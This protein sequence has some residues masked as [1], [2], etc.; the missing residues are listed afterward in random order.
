MSATKNLF[1]TFKTHDI[2]ALVKAA[3]AEL[4]DKP[5]ESLHKQ[6]YEGIDITPFY[7]PQ[8]RSPLPLRTNGA[9]QIA[10][11]ASW[12][13][14]TALLTHGADSVWIGVADWQEAHSL[15]LAQ[16]PQ[17]YHLFF[18]NRAALEAALPHTQAAK[19]LS[20]DP[21]A[22]ALRSGK[23]PSQADWQ[24][25][26]ALYQQNNAV[27]SVDI[28]PVHNAGGSATQELGI[29]LAM[30]V[31]NLHQLS[32]AQ[33][34]QPATLKV[35]VRWQVAIGSQYF[36]EI[37]KLRALRL[38][39]RLVADA[40]G[41]N[42]QL[43]IQAHTATWNKSLL[44]SYNNML[45]NTTEAMAAVIGGADVLSV[46]PHNHI[47]EGQSAFA[48]RI[49]LNTALLLREEAHLDK[50]ADAAAGAYFVEQLSDQL[51]DKAW[52]Y[53]QS[54]EAAGG[55]LKA[56]AKNIPQNDIAEVAT[57]KRQDFAAGKLVMV[58]VNKFPNA[59][60]TLKEV[61]GAPAP[62]ADWQAL[63]EQRLAQTPLT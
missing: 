38:L 37:A 16:A 18:D 27:L 46:W 53:F 32:E 22:L 55:F 8:G 59:K 60:D 19:S 45:R 4:K 10:A 56:A 6:S 41:L 29:G 58:G 25:Q 24:A 2:E 51:A 35:S 31:E 36:M 26:G 54:L 1:D 62:T 40:F 52:A 44:D 61:A 33:L 23:A 47:G 34:L 57:R 17:R 48:D 49:A 11:P 39:W 63:P 50:V 42:T 9:W 28:R 20:F 12:A 15:S 14:A 3:Q 43:E 30:L 7:H 21:L 13:S 5:L